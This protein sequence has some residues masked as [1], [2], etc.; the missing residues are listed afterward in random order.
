MSGTVEGKRLLVMGAGGLL[1]GRIVSGAL[2]EGA[3]VVALDLDTEDIVTN[4][5]KLGIGLDAPGLELDSM[6]VTNEEAVRGFMKD[7]GDCDGA[8]NATYPRNDRYG[9]HFF[10]VSLESF[11]ENVALHLGSSFLVTQQCAAYFSRRQAPFSLVN[12]ASV[13]GVMA[14]DFTVYDGTEM[15][16]PVEYAAVK[17]A[18]VHLAQYAMAYVRDSRFR[19]NCVSPGGILDAQP[20]TFVTAYSRKT[21][22]NRML[23]PEDVIGTILFLLSDQSAYVSGQNLVVDDGFTL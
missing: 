1:G 15:T 18:I 13:Y 12:I 5:G 11:N 21:R 8:V 19:V 23:D 16:M 2:A 6:D 3:K 22:G 10:D 9:A 7:P 4:L 14:P 17:S 20:E